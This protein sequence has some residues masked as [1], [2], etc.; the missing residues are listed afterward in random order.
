MRSRARVAARGVVLVV[1]A[2]LCVTTV[3]SGSF[4]VV[5]VPAVPVPAPAPSPAGDGG[6]A[7]VTPETGGEATGDAQDAPTDGGEGEAGTPA[8]PGAAAPDP[9]CLAAERAWAD[10]AE[11]QLD[12]TVEHPEELV[13]GFTAARDALAAAEP[14]AGVARDWDV[15]ATYVAMIAD[16]VEAAGPDDEAELARALDRV[17]RRIDTAALTGSSERVTQFFHAGCT[18]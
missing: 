2:G 11:A 16:A 4:D 13:E 6:T 9:A 1:M 5:T 7:P 3:A 15:V 12:V 18:A 17:G 14:P 10:A 8:G